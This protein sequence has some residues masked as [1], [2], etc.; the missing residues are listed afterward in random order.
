MLY[1]ASCTEVWNYNCAC[2]TV[3]VCVCVCVIPDLNVLVIC[4]GVRS[5]SRVMGNKGMKAMDISTAQL[6]RGEQVGIW[7]A[8]VRA[9]CTIRSN[10]CE[11]VRV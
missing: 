6:T 2:Y 3:C 9:N 11:G 4:M 5:R 10:W 8:L 7:P 1:N